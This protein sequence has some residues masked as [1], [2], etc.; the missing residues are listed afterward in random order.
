MYGKI[1]KHLVHFIIYFNTVESDVNQ[2]EELT[3][4][5]DIVLEDAIGLCRF[6]PH[7]IDVGGIIIEGQIYNWAGS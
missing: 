3:S 5:G 4:N 7:C 6:L 2:K 1:W